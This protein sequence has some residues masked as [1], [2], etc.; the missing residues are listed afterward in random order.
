M[1]LALA[2]AAAWF[3]P[4]ENILHETWSTADRWFPGLLFPGLGAGTGG[5]VTWSRALLMV[6]VYLAAL[7]AVRQP[8]CSAETSPESTRPT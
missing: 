6:T 3:F 4:F 8:R 5:A 2:V 7:I 1:P